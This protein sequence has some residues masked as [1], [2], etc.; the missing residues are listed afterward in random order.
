MWR[1]VKVLVFMKASHLSLLNARLLKGSFSPT[2]IISVVFGR[3]AATP[4]MC[5]WVT[6]VYA[7]EVSYYWTGFETSRKVKV[8]QPLVSCLPLTNIYKWTPCLRQTADV[9]HVCSWNDALNA[10]FLVYPDSPV[11]WEVSSGATRRRFRLWISLWHVV[12][13]ASHAWSFHCVSNG[14]YCTRIPSF[15]SCL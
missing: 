13:S 14:L 8:H 12:M 2:A 4:V 5:S 1:D 15:P 9:Q 11:G 3:L 7:H 6:F 10:L